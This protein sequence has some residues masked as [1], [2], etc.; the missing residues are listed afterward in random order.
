MRLNISFEINTEDEQ[1]GILQAR[2]IVFVIKENFS[3]SILNKSQVSL[4]REGDRSGK[5]LLLPRLEGRFGN[6]LQ[7]G[8]VNLKEIED[9]K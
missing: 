6:H 5:N 8:K 3:E 7:S 1:E 9:P 2:R 4:T